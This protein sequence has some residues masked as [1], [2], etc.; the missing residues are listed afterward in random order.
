MPGVVS[1]M[2]EVSERVKLFLIQA[3]E[4]RVTAAGASDSL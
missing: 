2:G 4:A 3:V 1:V